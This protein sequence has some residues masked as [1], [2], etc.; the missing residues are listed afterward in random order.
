MNTINA[1]D[2][3]VSACYVNMYVCMQVC[4]YVCTVCMYVCMYE[5]EGISDSTA[6]KPLVD[7]VGRL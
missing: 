4:M 5:T 1:M 7:V 3:Q 6:C 2:G